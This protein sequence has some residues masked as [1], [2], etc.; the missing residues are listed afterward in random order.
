MINSEPSSLSEAKRFVA[1]D[2]DGTLIVERHRPI[3]K[4]VDV[5]LIPGVVKA[6]QY[7]DTLKIGLLVITNQSG[8]GR[9]TLSH[10]ELDKIH[11]HLM[12][13]LALEGIQIQGIYSCTHAPWD[14]CGC[15]KPL[16][17]LLE[18]AATEHGFTS[19]DLYMIGDKASDIRCGRSFGAK[20]ILVRTGYG[21]SEESISVNI[22]DHIV[23]DLIEAAIVIERD[24]I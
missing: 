17:G 10:N 19:S 12:N 4:I 24:A 14:D 20:T 5:K 9:G 3:N 6:L 16:P 22:A 13:M 18:Q 8:V 23:E 2:R 1:L 21:K 11:S 7:L 15:R